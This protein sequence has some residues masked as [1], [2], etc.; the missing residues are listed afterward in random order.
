LLLVV[1]DLSQS[2]CSWSA[3]SG[4]Q[5]KEI[6]IFIICRKQTLFFSLFKCKVAKTLQGEI[7]GTLRINGELV[8]KWPQLNK[9]LLVNTGSS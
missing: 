2:Q 3:S 7:D 9:T 6:F 8:I 1:F 4:L 5:H